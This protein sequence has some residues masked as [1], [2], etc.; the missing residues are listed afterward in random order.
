V[1]HLSTHLSRTSDNAALLFEVPELS[2]PLAVQE[3]QVGGTS[4]GGSGLKGPIPIWK[5]ECVDALSSPRRR[6]P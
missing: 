4:V 6:T 2:L 5:T 3:L 1:L